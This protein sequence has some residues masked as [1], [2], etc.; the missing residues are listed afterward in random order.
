VHSHHEEFQ[1][2]TRNGKAENLAID[3]KSRKD[4]VRI[5]DGAV[6]TSGT[7]SVSYYMQYRDWYGDYPLHCHNVVHEDHAMMIR[8]RIVPPDDSKAGQ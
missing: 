1:L 7:G 6:G 8:F 2:L 3:D 5:G 4:V